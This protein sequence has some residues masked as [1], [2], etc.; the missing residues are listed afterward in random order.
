MYVV[1]MITLLWILIFLCI[2][3]KNLENINFGLILDA[4][5]FKREE[6]FYL[7]RCARGLVLWY[8]IIGE[9]L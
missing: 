7:F 3:F 5:H 6:V 4:I 2:K 1:I 9:S 8:N